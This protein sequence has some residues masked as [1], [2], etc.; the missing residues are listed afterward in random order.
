M[1][2]RDII[3]SVGLEYEH[4]S[5]EQKPKKKKGAASPTKLATSSV[6]E[7]EEEN[8]DAGD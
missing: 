3:E 7:F 4:V 6:E 8:I 2:N 5:Y 1:G